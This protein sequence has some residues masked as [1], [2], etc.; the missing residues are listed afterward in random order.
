MKDT[1]RKLH[2]L[3]A[4]FEAGVLGKDEY[5][6]SKETLDKDLKEFDNEV[7]EINQSPQE[8]EGQ[9]K[10]SD[11]SLLIAIAII[12]L[13]FVSIVAYSIF[14]KPKPMTLEDLHIFNL[15]LLTTTKSRWLLATCQND[16][17]KL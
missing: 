13:I 14:S 11:K 15:N 17:K 3:E 12:F 4:G 6:K 16:D 2:I 10:S 5:H 9:K 1:G 7:S 8:Q